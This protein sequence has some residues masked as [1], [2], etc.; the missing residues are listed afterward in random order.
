MIINLTCIVCRF[1]TEHV[2][3]PQGYNN[4]QEREPAM[5]PITNEI[6]IPVTNFDMPPSFNSIEFDA[7]VEIV[8]DKISSP[9]REVFQIHASRA[10][11]NSAVQFDG[12]LRNFVRSQL[13]TEQKVNNNYCS[14]KNMNALNKANNKTV[15]FQPDDSLVDGLHRIT[16]AV[17]TTKMFITDSE[18]NGSTN[19]DLSE[20]GLAKGQLP[21]CNVCNKEIIR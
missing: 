8:K 2:S 12:N 7:P 6:Y 18:S 11:D 13:N 21:V 16:G 9:N 5:S 14:T 1:L 19:S 15:M 17:T 20:M 4:M 3:P 10:F